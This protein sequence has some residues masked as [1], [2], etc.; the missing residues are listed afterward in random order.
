MII[1]EKLYEKEWEQ[2]FICSQCSVQIRAAFFSF[3]F[4]ADVLGW[5]AGSEILHL[6]K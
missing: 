3:L 5:N 4:W 2:P 1:H 6:A